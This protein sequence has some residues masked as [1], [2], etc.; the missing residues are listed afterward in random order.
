MSDHFIRFDKSQVDDYIIL[1][2][3]WVPV[4]QVLRIKKHL[5]LLK[6]GKYVAPSR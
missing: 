6:G 5:V 4:T 2:G 3:M 1:N